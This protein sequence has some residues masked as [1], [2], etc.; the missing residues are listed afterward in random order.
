MALIHKETIQ[1]VNTFLTNF[2]TGYKQWPDPNEFI[3]PSFKVKFEDGKYTE[4]TKSVLRI[5]DDKISGS[6]KPKEVQWNVDE[7]TYS[8]EEYSLGK[9]VSDKKKAQAEAPVNLDK[10]A[11][12]MVKR[13]HMMAREY[14]IQNIAGNAAVITNN[15]TPAI[16]WD[17]AAGT[18]ISDI[19][20]QMATIQRAT[21]GYIP[22]RIAMETRVALKMIKTTE[23]KNY[24]QPTDKGFTNGLWNAVAGLR[25]LGLE[26]FLLN[27]FGLSES[28]CTASDPTSEPLWDKKCLLF[29]CEPTPTLQTR[30]FMYSPYVARELVITT[31]EPRRRG[32]YHDIY[33]DIDELLVDV[34]CAY[35]FT[36]CIL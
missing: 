4:Y 1:N 32:V 3:A 11:V 30:T 6:E 34:D 26:P 15:G 9:F 27:N 21:A 13:F 18:P 28:K 7:T 10:D 5:Y 31:R 33:S 2:A 25:N 16:K 24:F 35:L 17:Q 22:N 19:L 8:C 14:R 12:K 23:W 36:N 20:D 29:Y